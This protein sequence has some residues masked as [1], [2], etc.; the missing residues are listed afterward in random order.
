[1]SQ[2]RGFLLMHRLCPKPAEPDPPSKQVPLFEPTNHT[3]R[4]NGMTS[5]AASDAM[6]GIDGMSDEPDLETD[7]PGH[8]AAQWCSECVTGHAAFEPCPVADELTADGAPLPP[9]PYADLAADDA[10]LEKFAKVFPFAH[11]AFAL[12]ADLGIVLQRIEGATLPLAAQ[13]QWCDRELRFQKAATWVLCE[14]ADMNRKE[15]PEFDRLLPL[16]RQ[17]MPKEL[18]EL[19]FPPAKKRRGARPLANPSRKGKSA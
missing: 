10:L 15:H 8:G 2:L 19:V 5:A 17:P 4:R 11:D 14:L 13:L 12:R 16:E 6:A 18:A 9:P 7:P 3:G 1:V